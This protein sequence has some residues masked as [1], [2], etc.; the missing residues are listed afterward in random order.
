VV[1]LLVACISTRSTPP[2]TASLQVTAPATPCLTAGAA[3]TPAPLVHY[4]NPALGF[5]VEHPARWEVT[6]LPGY[7]DALA[8]PWSAI[9]F[10]SDLYGYGEQVFGRYVATVAVGDSTGRSLTETVE[11]SLSHIVPSM[12]EGIDWTCC[13]KVGGEPAMELLLPWPMGGRSGSR[14]LVVIHD[15]REYRLTF[16]P[17]R[18]L[19]GVT[20]SD[21][22]ARAAFDTFLR[23]FTFVPIAPTA[24]LLRPTATPATTPTRQTLLPAPSPGYTMDVR[25]WARAAHR[26]RTVQL[27]PWSPHG[28]IA[29]ARMMRSPLLDLPPAYVAVILKTGFSLLALALTLVANRLLREMLRARFRDTPHAHTVFMLVRNAVFLAGASVILLIWLG[30]GSNFTVAMGILGAGIAFASQET[31]GSFAGYLS[32]V[33]GN[34][35]HIGDRVRIGDVTGDVLDISMLRTTLMEIGEWVKAEQYTGRVVTI[36]NRAVFSHPVFN[37]T[38]HWPYLWDEITIPV[39]YDSDWRRAGE[40]LLEHGEEYTSDLQAR[41]QARLVELMKRYPVHE[42]SVQPRLYV[43]MTDNWI[44]LTLR[45]VVEARERRKVVAKLH[46]ELLQHLQGEPDIAVASATFEIVGF[47]PLR[48]DPGLVDDLSTPAPQSQNQRSGRIGDAANRGF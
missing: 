31:I 30:F 7:V 25:G 36:A 3:L 26:H 19:D 37:Y 46:H 20:P 34:L 33:T 6:A 24:T 47:P 48:G 12:R 1:S 10:R 23:T 27:H 28:T 16:Y 18:T 11:Y 32:I 4:S 41:A 9:E 38:Q 17:R 13:L 42:Q 21:A 22:A 44:E 35:Y 43:V 40:I 5:A 14:Q 29:E 15:G 45:Y 8:R 39:T 2:A